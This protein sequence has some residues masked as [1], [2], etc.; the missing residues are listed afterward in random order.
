VSGY[1]VLAWE[2]RLREFHALPDLLPARLLMG[3]TSADLDNLLNV[4][5]Q[6]TREALLE[7][8]LRRI[9]AEERAG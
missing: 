1:G 2:Q 7:A 3:F 4:W 6:E 9:Q 5:S 8:I